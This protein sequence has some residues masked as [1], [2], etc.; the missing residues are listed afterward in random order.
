MSIFAVIR[1]MQLRDEKLKKIER[2]RKR[3]ENLKTKSYEDTSTKN[4]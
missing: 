2:K 3:L 4:S 1:F